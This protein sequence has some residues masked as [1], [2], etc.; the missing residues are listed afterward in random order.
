MT[1]DGLLLNFYTDLLTVERLSELSSRT[2]AESAKLFLQ[3]LQKEELK[4][5]AVTTRTLLYYLAWRRT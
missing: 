5:S 4:L 2:Y 3:W 1:I